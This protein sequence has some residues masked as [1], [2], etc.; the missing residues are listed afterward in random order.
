MTG[1]APVAVVFNT[2]FTAG[3]VQ[4]VAGGWDAMP[5]GGRWGVPLRERFGTAS[6]AEKQV[7]PACEAVTTR[8]SAVSTR[9]QPWDRNGDGLAWAP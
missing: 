8:P 2:P 6:S 1:S 5:T 9:F 3:V 4:A 7:A